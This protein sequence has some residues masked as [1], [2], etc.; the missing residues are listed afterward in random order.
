[1][2]LQPRFWRDLTGH[3]VPEIVKKLDMGCHPCQIEWLAADL[4]RPM[5][6]SV[7]LGFWGGLV[8][9]A[10]SVPQYCTRVLYCTVRAYLTFQ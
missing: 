9:L 7:V 1:M 3:L 4:R 10:Y 2:M 6:R 8:C 5:A